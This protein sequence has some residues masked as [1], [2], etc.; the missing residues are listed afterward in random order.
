MREVRKNQRMCSVLQLHDSVLQDGARVVVQ[1]VQPKHSYRHL[2]ISSR[3][4][5]TREKERMK[6]P[7]TQNHPNHSPKISTISFFFG[8][9]LG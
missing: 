4:I 1:L 5:K 2:T 9:Q 8:L 6:R 7:L 3:I